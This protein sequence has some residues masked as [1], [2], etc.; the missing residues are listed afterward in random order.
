MPTYYCNPNPTWKPAARLITSISHSYP[1]VVATTFNHGY[2]TGTVVRLSIPKACGMQQANNLFG[3]ITVIGSALFTI[4]I[5][6]RGFDRYNVPS[7]PL[8]LENVAGQA[9]PIA[10]VATIISEAVQCIRPV[11]I[12]PEDDILF[13]LAGNDEDEIYADVTGD[14]EFIGSSVVTVTGNPGTN[15][16]SVGGG[17]APGTIPS[18]VQVGAATGNVASLPLATDG[19]FLVGVTGADPIFTDFTL[20]GTVINQVPGPGTLGLTTNSATTIDFG[21]LQLA[22]PIQSLVGTNTTHGVSPASLLVKLGAQTANA[23][24]VGN[25]STAALSWTPAMKNGE[26]LIGAT[27]AAPMAKT[28]KAGSGI[29][30]KNASGYIKISSVFVW[31]E[32]VTT[33]MNLDAN[34]GYIAN[35]P[36]LLTFM[37]PSSA[38]IGAKIKIL[39][40]GTGLYRINQAAGQNIVGCSALTSI[41]ATGYLVSTSRYDVLELICIVTDT[42]FQ[43]TRAS[44]N[45]DLF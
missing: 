14:I 28:L 31:D 42:T 24:P 29:S 32:V 16:L 43:I 45:F 27:G 26:I 21:T 22:T 20:P 7:H 40:K 11:G 23:S 4:D 1:A 35:M 3:A 41:G 38:P 30:I 34:N 12:T 9:I 37:L 25:A 2:V 6:T 15:T 13:S 18:A 19:T 39:G 33:P 17:L 36:T 44:G 8:P 10:E 5:D